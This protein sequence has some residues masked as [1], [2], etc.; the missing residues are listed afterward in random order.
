M[1][2]GA[3]PPEWVASRRRNAPLFVAVL[4]AW[5]LGGSACDAPEEPLPVLAEVPDFTFL[6]QE[7]RTTRAE[8]FRGAPWVADFIFTRCTSACPMLTAQMGNLQRR[9]GADAARVRLAS[10]SVDP[11]Y[12]TPAV[13]K[14][15]AAAHGASGRWLFLTGE[16]AA[17][18][19]A[20]ERGF[21]LS[22]GD[23]RDGPVEQGAFDFMHAQHF[24]LVDAENRIRGYYP[25]D[26]DGIERLEHD[27]RRLLAAD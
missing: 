10:F 12:D 25:S 23:P 14:A 27:L 5:A 26:G 20:I 24:L 11:E 6:D 18:R 15:Y 3:R 9:L 17:M 22:M 7:G 21:R 1:Q 19:E 4:V 8:A 13:L 16:L 2:R